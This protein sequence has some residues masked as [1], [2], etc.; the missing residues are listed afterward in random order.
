MKAVFERINKMTISELED[1]IQAQKD[2]KKLIDSIVKERGQLLER[3]FSGI[4]RNPDILPYPWNETVVPLLAGY[5]DLDYCKFLARCNLHYQIEK[6]I[7][8]NEKI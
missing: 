3:L 7:S 5:D 2:N 8:K 1:D 6:S 4:L